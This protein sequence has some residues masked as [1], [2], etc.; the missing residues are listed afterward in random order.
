MTAQTGQ[1]EPEKTQAK[2][3]KAAEGMK[4]I[5]FL[6]RELNL[7]IHKFSPLYLIKVILKH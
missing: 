3:N 4:I 5:C 2:L 6:F 1:N 7:P